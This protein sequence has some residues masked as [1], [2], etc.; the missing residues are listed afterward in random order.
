MARTS[1]NRLL[2]TTG[3]KGGWDSAGW[4]E[5][6]G[7]VLTGYRPALR[8]LSGTGLGDKVLLAAV[9]PSGKLR[10]IQ[11]QPSSGSFSTWSEP[12][13]PAKLKFTHG[14]AIASDST[15]YTIVANDA[16]LG[17]QAMRQ[18][19]S[20]AQSY[21]WKQFAPSSFGGQ[22][23]L[24]AEFFHG[25]VRVFRMTYLNDTGFLE[26]S[27]LDQSSPASWRYVPGNSDAR[28]APSVALAGPDTLTL[29]S[30]QLTP[31]GE[32]PY[33]VN[34]GA[35]GVWGNWHRVAKN[36]LDS[37][38]PSVSSSNVSPNT[39]VYVIGMDGAV[40]VTAMKPAAGA[41]SLTA[42]EGYS[43][44][45]VTVPGSV[46]ST[47]FRPTPSGPDWVASLPAGTGLNEGSWETQAGSA[48]VSAAPIGSGSSLL[49]ARRRTDGRLYATLGDST[50]TWPTFGWAPVPGK[51]G[52]S[53]AAPATTPYPPSAVRYANDVY[54]TV[55]GPDHKLYFQVYNLP[56]RTWKADWKEIVA[57]EAGGQGLFYSGPS[58][59]V[60]NGTVHIV[61]AG[62]DHS[63]I[64]KNPVIG[65]SGDLVNRTEVIHLPGFNTTR[66]PG[67]AVFEN[68]LVVVA[69][70]HGN[71]LTHYYV[72]DSFGGSANWR[73]V[74]G[75]NFVLEDAPS[76]ALST[77]S[78]GRA[79][80]HMMFRSSSQDSVRYITAS[81]LEIDSAT[82]TTSAMR[83]LP[84]AKTSQEQVTTVSDG[85]LTKLF[86]VSSH[87]PQRPHALYELVYETEPANGYGM[88][89]KDRYG[90]SYVPKSTTEVPLDGDGK[91]IPA[92][93][94]PGDPWV[95]PAPPPVNWFVFC[96]SGPAVPDG[97]LP[98]PDVDQSGALAQAQQFAK[99]QYGPSGWT[100]TP[101]IAPVAGKC[102]DQTFTFCASWWRIP[103]APPL[104][105]G[106]GG[107]W[108]QYASFQANTQA[109][110]QQKALAYF[111]DP[112]THVDP[113]WD[114]YG[115][116]P[117]DSL[118]PGLTAAQCQ[119]GQGLSAEARAGTAGGR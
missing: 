22:F 56:S 91:P 18:S 46:P 34:M 88:V 44:S 35:S 73:V 108:W 65:A 106:A 17:I 50:T 89:W 63:L 98:A 110:A 5:I 95:P 68:R 100:L 21:P 97:Y 96:L 117:P 78:D 64:W 13:N 1:D 33:Y 61:A 90:L 24:S 76:L 80:L 36:Q 29:V 104:P 43:D 28:T 62:A 67:L 48:G 4:R 41:D 103:P 105:N 2:F 11:Y 99:E 113:A 16:S 102:Q 3:G 85:G 77:A 8:S 82:F 83:L 32:E 51:L 60:W 7:N 27:D 59:V 19:S 20:G 37:S 49:I 10:T 114:G 107:Y 71:N 54:V 25:V 69:Q 45:F 109:E 111:T 118:A 92:P 23:D 72:R 101:E 30:T 57:G 115:P 26:Y 75:T 42:A 31:E 52:G 93:P 38:F 86:E 53:A 94:G 6:P 87:D 119:G 79:V 40:G 66:A 9:D 58:M 47:Y 74:P 12:S 81:S 15:S 70:N 112:A 84:A 14:P 39:H 116:V 55:V